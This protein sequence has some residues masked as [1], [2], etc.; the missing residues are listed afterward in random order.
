MK[1]WIEI[2]YRM[3]GR[4]EIGLKLNER[5]EGE[6]LSFG[7]SDNRRPSRQGVQGET[8]IIAVSWIGA[9]VTLIDAVV[10]VCGFLVH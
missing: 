2:D 4:E 6:M 10:F 7:L 8:N 1:D 5:K 9:A 3:S